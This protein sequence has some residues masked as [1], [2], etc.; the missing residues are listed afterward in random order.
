MTATVLY[1]LTLGERTELS[2]HESWRTAWEAARKRGHHYCG[3]GLYI[4]DAKKFDE[5]IAADRAF[6]KAFTPNKHGEYA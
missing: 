4:E 6:T 5:M 3:S 2:R 1:F